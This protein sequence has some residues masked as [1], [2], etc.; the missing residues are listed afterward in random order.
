[1]IILRVPDK[2][3]MVRLPGKDKL[4]GQVGFDQNLHCREDVSNFGWHI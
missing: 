3:D 2:L 4:F 1:M